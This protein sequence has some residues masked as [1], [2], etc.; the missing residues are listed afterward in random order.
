MGAD[1]QSRTD[2][3]WFTS[4]TIPVFMVSFKAFSCL[5]VREPEPS[6]ASNASS[7]G[8]CRRVRLETRLQRSIHLCSRDALRFN[9]NVTF[10]GSRC[11]ENLFGLRRVAVVHDLHVLA[12]TTLRHS[13]NRRVILCRIS[14]K[15]VCSVT[16]DPSPGGLAQP[17][18]R[19]RRHPRPG[20]ATCH[21]HSL[22]LLHPPRR[23]AA[24]ES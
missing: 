17:Q 23:V 8:Y 3:R 16:H 4:A 9:S 21:G 14:S 11:T 7:R 22:P 18:S 10:P 24:T 1:G 2:D 15:S 19:R 6:N 5:F 20:R 13:R 12:G